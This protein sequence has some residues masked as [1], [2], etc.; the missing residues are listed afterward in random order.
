MAM[1][2]NSDSKEEGIGEK[3]RI[4]KDD[5]KETPEPLRQAK[6]APPCLVLLVG[7]DSFI[8]KQWP[9]EG[10]DIILGRAEGSTIQVTD[11][12]L[13]KSHAKI[14]VSETN[15][16]IT[17]LESTNKTFINGDL[18]TPLKPRK[19]LN[20]DQIKM[21][22]IIFKFLERGNIETIST[23]EAFD[24]GNT[25]PLTGIA[26]KGSFNAAAKEY[27]TRSGGPLGIPLSILTFDVDHFKKVNDINGHQAGDYVLEVLAK[28]VRDK[29][30]REDDF[31][32]RTG[33]EEFSVLLLGSPMEKAR[34]VAERLRQ[35][36]ESFPFEFSDI[37]IPITVSVGVAERKIEDK[38]WEQVFERADK[39]LYEAKNSGRN[40]VKAN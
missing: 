22:N 38:A 31:F 1:E 10:G 19:L 26:N 12:N 20:N 9:L 25:D 8:G 27:F 4:L 35:T 18:V 6:Q 32:A 30:I 24:R 7:P 17:D 33:G 13:S 29:V 23:A 37:K 11:K 16:Y 15:V 21:G 34:E 14:S 2:D 36:A 5:L 40:Q 39:A 3:T 28:T